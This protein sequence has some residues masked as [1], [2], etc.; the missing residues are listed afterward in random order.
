[1]LK[2]FLSILAV[3]LVLLLGAFAAWLY[4]AKNSD[5]VAFLNEVRYE[6][7]PHVG[8]KL[9]STC[10]LEIYQQWS[11]HSRHAVSTIANSV[12]SVIDNLKQHTILNYVLGGEDM[13]YACHGPKAAN[14]GVNC[15]TCHGPAGVFASI[16]EAHEQKF[17]PRM[18]SLKDE[19]FCA[20]CHEIP[21][22]VTPFSDWQNSVAA[23]NGMTCQSCHM[24]APKDGVSYHGFDSFVLNEQIYENDLELNDIRLDFP[25]LFLTIENHLTGHS[26]PA[27]GPTRILALEVTF[28]DL[29][30]NVIHRDMKTFAKYHNLI[31]V[32][33][34]WPNEIIADTTLKSLER[35]PLSFLL[36][37]AL[38][39][40]AYS[41]ELIL[42][43]YEVADE[44]AGNIKKARYVSKPVLQKRI[45]G[46]S[47][48]DRDAG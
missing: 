39:A 45:I 35:R 41:V 43:F 12:R 4:S 38:T 15:E 3:I 48:P 47:R 17:K 20:S 29:E 27:G 33:G 6:A 13:C 10:H 2:K 1:M 36:P 40:E 44:H 5:E 19:A 32:L 24:S 31:P 22:F 37:S 46:L 21:G 14:E 11:N 25:Y 34:F 28:L 18:K 26:I 23:S 8:A 7:G 42:R 30:G 16:E 9:C